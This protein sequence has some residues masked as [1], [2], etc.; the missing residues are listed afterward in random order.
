MTTTTKICVLCACTIWCTACK[1]TDKLTHTDNDIN[2][3]D[4]R[5]WGSLSRYDLHLFDTIDVWTI[6]A[7]GDTATGYRQPYR[8]IRHTRLDA[9][10]AE[11]DTTQQNTSI[12]QRQKTTTTKK[13]N[14]FHNFYTQCKCFYAA[15]FIVVFIVLTIRYK[16]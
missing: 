7:A 3:S 13:E 11:Q 14:T 15:V 4:I 10:V 16:R 2:I 9:V 1:S 12:Q 8:T 6:P 5:T